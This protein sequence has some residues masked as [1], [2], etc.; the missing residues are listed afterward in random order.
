MPWKGVTEMDQRVRVISEYLD[1]YFSIAELCRQF[2]V[3]RKTGYKW[4][5]RYEDGSRKWTVRKGKAKKE[6]TRD[7]KTKSAFKNINR[8]KPDK[9]SSCL[10]DILGNTICN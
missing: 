9:S 2:N 8:A 10:T 1:G 4:I 7:D 5:G 6:D 3:S